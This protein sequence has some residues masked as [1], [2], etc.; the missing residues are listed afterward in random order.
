MEEVRRALGRKV[1][2]LRSELE[3]SQEQLAE[4]AGLH[5]THISG[6]ERGRH[7]LTLTTL[8]KVAV[9]LRVSLSELFEGVGLHPRPFHRKS[10]R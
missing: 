4:R 9:A 8:C 2:K 1:R 6:I 10:T 3:L 5:W 7:N